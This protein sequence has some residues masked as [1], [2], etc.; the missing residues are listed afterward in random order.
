MNQVKFTVC[1]MNEI[2][3]KLLFIQAQIYFKF[4]VETKRTEKYNRLK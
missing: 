4:A 1:N 3:V 2:N